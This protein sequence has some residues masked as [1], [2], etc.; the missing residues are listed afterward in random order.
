MELI[1]VQHCHEIVSP[2]NV[3]DFHSKA[4]FQRSM[5]LLLLLKM[6]TLFDEGE[7]NEVFNIIKL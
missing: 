6:S 4:F 1:E 7:N 2:R 3:Y 5:P